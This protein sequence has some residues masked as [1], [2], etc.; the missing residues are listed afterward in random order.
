MPRERHR[1]K[2]MEEIRKINYKCKMRKN[3]KK[4]NNNE[5]KSGKYGIQKSS[6]TT[7]KKYEMS[8]ERNIAKK[9]VYRGL[10]SSIT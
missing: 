3:I 1:S 8:K 2:Y 7:K 9:Q 5:R 4:Y 6:N 10:S